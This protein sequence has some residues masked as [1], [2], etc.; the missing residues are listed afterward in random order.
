MSTTLLIKD[1]DWV[2]NSATGRPMTIKDGPKFK[3]DL[4]CNF[5]TS[6]RFNGF[7]AGLEELIGVVPRDPSVFTIMADQRLRKSLTSMQF[8]Q[9]QITV[10]PR[11]DNELIASIDAVYVV[12][13][14]GDPRVYKYFVSITTVQGQKL[15]AAGAVS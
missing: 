8:L 13:D 15:S 1:G 6:T 7:G 5:T 4:A 9:R 12:Q 14:T 3:Q 2:I 10:I 11:P